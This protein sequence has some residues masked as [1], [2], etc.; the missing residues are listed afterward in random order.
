MHVLE[1]NLVTGSNYDYQ[2]D[3]VYYAKCPECAED[4]TGETIIRQI[5]RLKDHS[6]KDLKSH[7]LKHSVETNHKTV[8]LHDFKIIGVVYKTSKFRRK[9]AESLHIKEKRSSLNTQ[10][11]SIPL[12]LFN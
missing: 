10:E 12:K 1:L 7:L 11:A 3:V 6:G 4:Y 9:L 8:T 5:E 2:H